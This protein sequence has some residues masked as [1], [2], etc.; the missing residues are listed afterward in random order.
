M[1]SQQSLG[2]KVRCHPNRRKSWWWA[3]TLGPVIKIWNHAHRWLLLAK[4]EK[5]RVCYKE[6]NEYFLSL[7]LSL[8]HWEWHTFLEKVSQQDSYQI[9]N[10]TKRQSD[11]NVLLL[12]QEDGTLTHLKHQQAELLLAG[13]SAPPSLFSVEDIP[14]FGQAWCVIYPPIVKSEVSKVLAK[15]QPK[16]S[17]GIDGI[18]NETLRLASAPLVPLLTPLFNDIIQLISFTTLWKSAV[19]IIIRKAGKKDYTQLEA[20]HLIALLNSIFKIFELLI[21]RQLTHW[22]ELQKILVE[23]H[24]GGRKGLGAN[25]T[26]FLLDKWV[27]AKWS[28]G[29][30]VEALFLYLKSA[31]PSFRPLCM[32]QML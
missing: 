19:T 6:W 15:A 4:T 13:T 20:Y 2:C 29:E 7:V 30:T 21:A 16:K 25:E 1:L 17:C 28:K 5:A 10:L 11:S 9:S 8:K 26:L 27:R 24:L 22:A 14:P 18:E 32:I 31:Y 23:G 3:S 12:H